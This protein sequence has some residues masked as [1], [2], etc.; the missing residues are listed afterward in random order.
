MI[1]CD[2]FRVRYPSSTDEPAVLEHLRACD[3]CLAAVATEDPD[4]LFRAIGGQELLPPGGVDAF[5]GDVMR[6]VRLR[7][8]EN[9]MERRPASWSR[10]LAIAATLAI[11]LIG[12]AVVYQL[13]RTQA[14]AP[15]GIT[16]VAAARPALTTLAAVET[17]HSETA[18]IIE[19]PA[20]GVGDVRVVMV[21]DETLPVDL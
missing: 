6:E 16:P 2:L 17:Y 10:R 19:V 21:F 15:A 9:S 11:G 3:A 5:V 12:G 20:E 8:T 1:S 7:S 18:T 4:A 13:E 14:P